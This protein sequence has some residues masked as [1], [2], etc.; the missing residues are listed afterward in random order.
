MRKLRFIAGIFCLLI[1]PFLFTS[2]P[3]RWD[4][5]SAD[6]GTILYFPLIRKIDAPSWIGPYGGS[7]VAIAADPRQ[8]QV[9]YAGTWGGGI[10]K[11]VDGGNNWKFAGNGLGVMYIDS[12]A[13]DPVVTTTVYAGTHGGGVYKSTDGGASWT[14][15]NNGI[16]NRAVVYTITVN[17]GN[18][19][20]VY[21]GTRGAP[22]TPGPPWSGILYKSN[23]GGASWY[24]VLTNVG[25]SDQQDWVYSVR[26]NPSSPDTL[27][28][29]THEH[30]P[31]LAYD[32]GGSNDW[33]SPE[34]VSDWSGRAVAFDPRSW[35]YAAYYATWHGD[36]IYKST[37]GG[38]HWELSNDGMGYAKIYP[39]GIA[40]EPANPSSIYLASFGDDVHGVLRSTNSGDSW[41]MT[42]FSSQKI[43]SVET[44]AY[45]RDTVI[46][47]TFHDGLY[48]STNGGSNWSHTIN[49]LIN[50]NV[51]AM[52]SPG[53]TTFYSSTLGGGVSRSLDGGVS[54]TEFNQNLSDRNING[55]VLHPA[56]PNILFALTSSL[57]L[58]KI[59]LSG[60]SGWTQ[61]SLPLAGVEGSG[62][63]ALDDPLARHEPGEEMLDPIKDEGPQ[64]GQFL[65]A[66]ISAPVLS[67]A[68]APSSSQVAF[69]G[70]NGSG[71]YKTS[72]GGTSWGSAGLAG[73]A[74]RSIAIHP[75]NANNVY[76][77]TDQAGL[78]KV[79]TDGG[80]VWN[81]LTTIPGGPAIYAVAVL[82]WEPDTVYAGT[83]NGIW[84]FTGSGWSQS[85]LPGIQVTVLRASPFSSKLMFAGTTNGAYFSG[86]MAAWILFCPDSTGYAISSIDFVTINGQDQ[87]YLG[88][89][90]R[91]IL[92][93]YAP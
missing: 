69:V 81:N 61:A 15:V 67:M 57:G 14:A 33:Y 26:A 65:S 1:L 85:G 12:M 50:S 3:G 66:G 22:E 75:A 72:N 10:Y 23:N 36:G 60:T 38:H 79:T 42:S 86:D 39:N 43:Y 24:P 91:G 88:T 47:G 27:L 51:T 48:K 44:P 82:P 11:S 30:G 2:G 13:V 56:N 84:K 19:S 45:S 20:L 41:Y 4:R 78:L 8:S 77:A 29:A 83:S 32:Y 5:V 35:T 28:A 80:A 58:R 92:K 25:G 55:L 37:N 52:V 71:M 73:R 70:T 53:G 40:I 21:A 46:A 63:I 87:V 64:E 7:V 54:W 74:V 18:H 90:T 34:P 62:I 89:T 93:V 76:A 31:Y 17:P 68:F 9:I 16:Q 59:D 49:G 6:T